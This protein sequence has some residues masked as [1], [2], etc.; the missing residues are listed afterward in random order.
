[1][2]TNDSLIMGPPGWRRCWPEYLLAQTFHRISLSQNSLRTLLRRVII[3]VDLQPV[4]CFSSPILEI[5]ISEIFCFT[6][7]IYTL[8][9]RVDSRSHVNNFHS[10]IKD[11]TTTAMCLH[12]ITLLHLSNSIDTRPWTRMHSLHSLEL[13]LQQLQLSHNIMCSEKNQTNQITYVYIDNIFL[14]N[15]NID[16]TIL[17]RRGLA[18]FGLVIFGN[19]YYVEDVLDNWPARWSVLSAGH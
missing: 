7:Y 15:T 13:P 12:I 11:D 1:M 4:P 3:S 6:E 9:T 10:F 5:I 18:G 16:M 17:A 19:E 8:H 14:I 2:V